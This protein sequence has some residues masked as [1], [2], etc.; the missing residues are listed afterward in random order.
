MKRTTLVKTAQYVDTHVEVTFVSVLLAGKVT[1][2][3]RVS[4]IYVYY[5]PMIHVHV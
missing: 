2:V 1:I 3:M 5:M 4:D